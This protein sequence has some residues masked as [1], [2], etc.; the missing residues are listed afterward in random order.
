MWIFSS[1]ENKS[2]VLLLQEL[3]QHSC[4]IKGVH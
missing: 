4:E 2:V 1:P 3:A